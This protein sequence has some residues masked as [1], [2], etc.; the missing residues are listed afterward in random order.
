MEQTILKS[1]EKII[2]VTFYLN[3]IFAIISIFYQNIIYNYIIIFSNII[4][5]GS[6]LIIKKYHSTF[7]VLAQTNKVFKNLNEVLKKTNG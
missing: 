7:E 1:S 6:Y 4:L 3:V 5:T 2:K